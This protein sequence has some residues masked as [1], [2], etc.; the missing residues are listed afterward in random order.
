VPASEQSSHQCPFQVW[1]L[2]PPYKN[3]DKI[4]FT[5]HFTEAID[6]NTLILT[7]ITGDGCLTTTTGIGMGL[8]ITGCEEELM[9]MIREQQTRW[10]LPTTTR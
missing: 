6:P 3:S 2:S 9:T 7:N 5:Y 10:Q 8:S 4:I 1:L